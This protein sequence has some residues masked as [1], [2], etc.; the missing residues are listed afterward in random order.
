MIDYKEI[1]EDQ[2]K[3]LSQQSR[4]TITVLSTIFDNTNIQYK[5]HWIVDKIDKK[6]SNGQESIELYK[7]GAKRFYYTQESTTT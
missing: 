6:L 4:S 7:S 1:F 5:R 3:T 2:I